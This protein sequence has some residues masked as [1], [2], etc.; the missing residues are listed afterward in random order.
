[1]PWIDWSAASISTLRIDRAEPRQDLGT[2]PDEACVVRC[3]NAMLC[4]PTK[5][6]LVPDLGD[7]LLNAIEPPV[8]SA[9]PYTVLSVNPGADNHV[10]RVAVAKA[11]WLRS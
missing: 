4:W 9:T 5:L 2:K 8:Q 11:P 1:M 3:A 7:Q 10:E 6:S